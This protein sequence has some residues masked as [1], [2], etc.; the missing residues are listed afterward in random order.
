M[1]INNLPVSEKQECYWLV[2]YLED[3]IM[4]E[5]IAMYTHI[6]NSTYT[7]SWAAKMMNKKLGVNKGFPDYIILARE[8]ALA[9]EMKTEKD[10]YA[11]PEQKAWIEALQG[12][13]I[14][15]KVCR[16]FRGAKQFLD[17]CLEGG[18]TI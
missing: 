8:K 1:K 2:E 14:H 15:A 10:G 3:L 7:K 18:V 12:A 6:P 5:K 9:I 16:G 17:E 4:K 13:G 11:R